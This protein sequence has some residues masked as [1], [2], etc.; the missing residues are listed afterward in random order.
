MTILIAS[1]LVPDL[2]TCIYRNIFKLRN[3]CLQVFIRYSGS[4]LLS[5]LFNMMTMNIKE[6]LEYPFYQLSYKR[7]FILFLILL[8]YVGYKIIT[9]IRIETYWTKVAQLKKKSIDTKV[10]KLKERLEKTYKPSFEK[11]KLILNCT[12]SDLLEQ[13]RARKLTSVELV[14]FYTHRCLHLAYDMNLISDFVYDEAIAQAKNIDKVYDENKNNADWKP[15]E[16]LFGIPCTIKDVFI[17]KDCDTT[18]GA[19]VNCFKPSKDD[20]LIIKTLK[21]HGVIP[22]VISTTPQLM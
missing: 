7:W 5:P 18:I 6:C 13:L 17:I 12:V 19:T 22:F 16:R 9:K 3:S 8:V 15:Q 4:R 1:V 2:L 10:A 21:S 20:G 14:N 11:T